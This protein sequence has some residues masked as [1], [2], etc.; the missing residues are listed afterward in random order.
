LGDVY[1]FSTRYTMNI[2]HTQALGVI[3]KRAIL[4]A[5]SESDPFP[6]YTVREVARLF[7]VSPSTVLT[8]RKQG[9]IKGRCHV[10]S[11]R[12]W[13]W[14]F[15]HPDVMAFFD[16]NFPSEDDTKVYFELQPSSN[17]KTSRVI[18]VQKMLAMRRLYARNH[19]RRKKA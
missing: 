1:E 19:S 15:T 16:K 4:E 13:R 8:W 12:S 10:L 11:G 14:L 7:Y 6:L 9:L 3:V 17:P 2:Q 18:Q 5:L